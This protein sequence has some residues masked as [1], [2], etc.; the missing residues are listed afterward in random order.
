MGF[1]ICSLYEAQYQAI[2]G[3]REHHKGIWPETGLGISWELS[4][5]LRHLNKLYQIGQ[6]IS[7]AKSLGWRLSRIH[8]KLPSP[9]GQFRLQHRSMCPINSS[10]ISAENLAPNSH[11]RETS[12]P[13]LIWRKSLTFKRQVCY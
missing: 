7:L 11:R 4:V 12:I 3:C 5:S 2:A 13:C 10:L 6:R 9:L 8:P 1:M